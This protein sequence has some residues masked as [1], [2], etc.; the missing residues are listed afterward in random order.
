MTCHKPVVL[1]RMAVILEGRP[2]VYWAED[3]AVPVAH[4]CI[5][6]KTPCVCGGWIRVER[7][8]GVTE[9]VRQHQA[10][11]LHVAWRLGVPLDKVPGTFQPDGQPVM[12]ARG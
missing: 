11:T 12:S 1:R 10:S 7:G 5:S 6:M 8:Q 9:V 2:R 4:E 3:D